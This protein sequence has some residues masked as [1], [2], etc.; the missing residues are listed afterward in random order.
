MKLLR[1][2]IEDFEVITES[3]KDGN[4]NHYI[5]GI[6]MQAE[7]KNQNGRIYPKHVMESGVNKYI[8]ELVSKNRAVGTLDHEDTPRVSSDRV[9]HLITDLRME[10]NDVIGKAKVLE[11][12]CGKQLKAM[13]E[14][15]V[16]FGVSS[17][18]LG[19]LKEE[20]GAKIVQPDFTISAIDAVLNP[21]CRAAFVEGIL[22]EAEWVMINGEWV[23][24][25][26]EESQKRI[27]KST[28]KEIESVALQIWENY[29]RNL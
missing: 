1:E 10:G 4:K 25:H 19:S 7:S 17:R 11:T 15:G 3:T 22:E 2:E 13:I 6:F 18:A 9:S 23:K 27:H 21:S 16:N 12:I 24:S 20:N 28:K 14:G 5:H 26:L 29:V 8:E